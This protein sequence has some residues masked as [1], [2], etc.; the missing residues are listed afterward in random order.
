MLLL[1]VLRKS[2]FILLFFFNDTATTEIYTLSL[3]DALPIY[4]WHPVLPAC[5][6]FAR[7]FSRPFDGNPVGTPGPARDWR[8]SPGSWRRPAAPP[9]ELTGRPGVPPPQPDCARCLHKSRRWA[10]PRHALCPSN[11]D[12]R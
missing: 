4:W 12:T 7:P 10:A 9:P 5:P 6:Q 8:W 11:R 1:D 2:P 3:H